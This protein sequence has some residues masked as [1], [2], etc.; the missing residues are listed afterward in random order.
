M[1]PALSDESYLVMMAERIT[2]IIDKF[3][4]HI[5]TV[6]GVNWWGNIHESY[7]DHL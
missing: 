4:L 1:L 7:K 5:M 3:F 2:P 6:S